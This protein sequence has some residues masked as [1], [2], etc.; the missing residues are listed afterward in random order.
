V[1][2]L[3][4]VLTFRAVRLVRA[5]FAGITPNSEVLQKRLTFAASREVKKKTFKICVF[6]E[7]RNCIESNDLFH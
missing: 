5:M 7:P 2:E 4:R 1:D 3:K 6:K